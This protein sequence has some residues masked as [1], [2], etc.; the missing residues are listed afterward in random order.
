MLIRQGTVKDWPFMYELAKRVIPVNIS[1]W[2][3]QPM[4]ETMKYRIK[5]LKNFWTWINQSGSKVFIAEMEQEKPAGFLVLYPNAVEELTGLPQGW[6]MD[7]AVLEDYRNHGIGRVLMEAAETYCREQGIEY[8]G[9]AVSSHNVQ[10][11][12]LYQSLGFAE[13]R[14][15]MVKVLKD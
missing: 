9:L 3:Q 1:P 8:L 6:V 7:I 11:V 13:E 12:K 15:L 5:M 10:A 2:R 14:K 4:E